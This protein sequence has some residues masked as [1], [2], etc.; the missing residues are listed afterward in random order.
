M[1][2][3]IMGKAKLTTDTKTAPRIK[4]LA[5]YV[6]IRPSEAQ[7]KTAS[8]IY[9]PESAQEKKAL[10]EVVSIGEALSLPGGHYITCP[11]KVGDRVY[12]KKWGGDEIDVEGEELKLVKFEDLIAILES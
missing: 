10:G 3:Y 2:I 4:P 9:L 6:L 8:G 7:T 1:T 12:Y 11:V 5:G